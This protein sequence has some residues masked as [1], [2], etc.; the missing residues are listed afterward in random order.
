MENATFDQYA[1]KTYYTRR[2]ILDLAARERLMVMSYHMPFPAQEHM[3][4]KGNHYG[5]EPAPRIFDVN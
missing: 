2:R 3:F 5:W 1:K 4:T